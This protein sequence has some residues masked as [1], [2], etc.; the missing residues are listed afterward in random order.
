MKYLRDRYSRTPAVE[1]GPLALKAV[2]EQMVDDGLSRRY[3]NDLVAGSNGY[4]SGPSGSNCCRRDYSRL[5]RPSLA[6]ARAAP[7]PARANRSYRS[8]TPRSTPRCPTCPRCRRTWFASSGSR[9]C[10]RRK[11]ASCDH[12]TSTAALI[13]GG[14]RPHHHKTQHTRPRAGHFYWPASPSHLASLPGP[15]RRSV[16]LPAVRLGSETP[17][18]R[19]RG[20]QT[21]TFVRQSSG[22]KPTPEA[23]TQTW[24][25]VQCRRL[26]SGHSS[27]VRQGFPCAQGG[28]R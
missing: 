11:C 21:P 9:G 12:A 27:S 2:R 1:F 16:L 15:R 6:F 7:A 25:C 10:D 19:S 18:S 17:C 28:C 22:H 5:L 26:P 14:T 24:R 23:E 4:S 8:T 20:P 3:V 13:R